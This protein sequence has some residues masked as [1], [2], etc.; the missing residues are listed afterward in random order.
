M[1]ALKDAEF[2][3]RQFSLLWLE[4]AVQT[5]LAQGVS[6]HPEVT[7]LAV[8]ATHQSDGLV[9]LEAEFRDARGDAVMGFGL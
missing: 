4:M 7:S 3:R 6:D 5:A 2:V 8:V 9:V 1:D